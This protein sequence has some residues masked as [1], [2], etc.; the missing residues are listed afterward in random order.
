MELIVKHNIQKEV[1]ILNQL[2]DSDP[3][4]R[5]RSLQYI[6]NSHLSWSNVVD[7]QSVLIDMIEKESHPKVIRWLAYSLAEINAGARAIKVLNQKMNHDCE[8][9]VR[10]WL[11]ASVEKIKQKHKLT[12]QSKIYELNSE[13]DLHDGIIKSWSYKFLPW[14]KLKILIDALESED[15]STRRWAVLSLGE[16]EDKSKFVKDAIKSKFDDDDYLVR[17]WSMYALK[18][19]A[20]EDDFE[21]YL[22]R[23]RDEDHVRAREWA[24]KGIRF[25]HAR[26]VPDVI[27]PE[28]EHEFFTKDPL[29]AEAVVNTLGE[30]VDKK[31]VF[32]KLKQISKEAH[33]DLVLLACTSILSNKFLGNEEAIE[34]LL[35]VF[36]RLSSSSS[37]ERIVLEVINLL[38]NRKRK[39]FVELI[40]DSASRKVLTGL[41][42]DSLADVLGVIKTSEALLFED[43]SNPKSKFTEEEG[44]M[45]DK[46]SVELMGDDFSKWQKEQ[47][48]FTAS[49]PKSRTIDEKVIEK[50]RNTVEVLI[51]TAVEVELSSVLSLLR[52]LSRRKTISKAY[53][54][55]ETYYLG[56]FG[57]Y[58]TAVMKCRAGSSDEG[59]VVFSVPDAVKLWNPRVTVMVGIA[60]GAYPKKQKIGDVLVA[61]WIIP[62]ER[63]RADRK[64]S[65]FRGNMPASNTTIRNRFENASDWKFDSGRIGKCEI[66]VGP[67]LSGEK[68]LDDPKFKKE[69]LTR[70]PQVIGGEMEGV[71]LSAA[72]DRM[73]S[74]WIL[75]KSICDWADGKKKKIYQPFAAAAACSLVYH[76]LSQK[77]VIKHIS[78]APDQFS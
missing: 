54:G 33:D 25:T 32:D 47:S 74:A 56:K 63:I 39:L 4:L 67:I 6:C 49:K 45:T 23:L 70:Y 69:L 40:S 8:P 21:L 26:D 71:G 59:S 16:K 53:V 66:K 76:V 11:L 7:L 52:P 2:Q 28:T 77:D 78:R 14:D 68:L 19:I 37:R 20:T 15:P 1:I 34:F 3:Q 31:E 5:I 13:I 50:M 55:H 58:N 35:D 36:K 42:S 62:Y 73:R 30:F 29:F 10:E 43:E 75:V 38:D 46:S 44:E 24:V 27:L 9:I 17:E 61:S 12:E 60:F 22:K 48:W 41:L 18:D 64:D 72:S 51:V 57:L 65:E